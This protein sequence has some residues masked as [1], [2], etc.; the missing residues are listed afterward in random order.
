MFLK[1]GFVFVSGFFGIDNSKNVFMLMTQKIAIIAVSNKLLKQSF[2]IAKS[3][4]LYNLN[5]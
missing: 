5:L 4:L 2:E 3:G 1:V